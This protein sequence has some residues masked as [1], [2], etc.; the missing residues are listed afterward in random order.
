MKVLH[1][2]GARPNFPKT[3]P[4]MAE[5]ARHPKDFE[6]VLVHTGQHYDP[7]MSDVFFEDL[8]MPQPDEFLNVGSGT[9]AEQTARVMLA[10]EP[11][12]LKHRPDW[13]FV[14]GDVNS[15]VACALV[16]AKLGVRVAH[17]EAGLRSGDR[18][19]PE[20]INRILTDQLADLLFTPSR[21]G[22]ENLQ[23]EGIALEKIHFVG[24]VMIDTL[25][26]M[27]S[28]ALE[29]SIVADLG[30][31]P[32]KYVL[33]TLHRPSNVDDPDT[34]REIL[35][36]L[37]EVS[38]GSSVVFPVHPRTQKRI[39]SMDLAKLNSN[40][41]FID[42]LGYLD[43]LSMMNFAQLVITDSGGVQEET[44]Y[45]GV[46]CL[47]VRPNTERPVT[48]EI[49]TNRLVASSCQAILDAV[50]DA[51]SN[52]RKEGSPP[53]RW[54]GLASERIGKVMKDLDAGTAPTT[55]LLRQIEG[56]N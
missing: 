41:R 16:C 38:A 35:L 11:V 54:D 12:V 7:N 30:L 42:P 17:V 21:D 4:I 31:E 37:I 10:F 34:L 6:Q 47:T 49:G 39:E 25:V 40:I 8:D 27:L 15:T 9:H 56:Y 53:D 18:S 43:F 29:R 32:Q 22:D 48:I 26:K 24:N 3:A 46:Q 51:M 55:N 52:R 19:M 28:R 23:K 44:T 50:Q 13:V 5:M 1:V 45:L 36:A 20:E 33:V 2:V 14:V